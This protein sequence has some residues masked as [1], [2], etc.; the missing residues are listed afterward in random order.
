MTI[1]VTI[2]TV[3]V[4]VNGCSRYEDF[5]PLTIAHWGSSFGEEDAQEPSHLSSLW[6]QVPT[7]AMGRIEIRRS[8]IEGK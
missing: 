3:N 8:Q 6:K 2:A 7:E 1:G 5:S 4:C